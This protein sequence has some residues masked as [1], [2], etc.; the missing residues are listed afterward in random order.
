MFYLMNAR[1]ELIER[2]TWLEIDFVLAEHRTIIHTFIRD[3]MN[4]DAC[5]VYFTALV[6]F[7]CAFDSVNPREHSWQCRMK[8]DHTIWKGGKKCRGKNSHPASEDNVVRNIGR[9][10]VSEARVVSEAR[11][12]FL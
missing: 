11:L 1:F 7:I 3:E 8:V 5:M 10:A 12:I 9:H 6:G 2:F 4:H